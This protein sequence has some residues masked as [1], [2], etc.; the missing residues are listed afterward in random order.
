MKLQ[1]WIVTKYTSGE[2]NCKVFIVFAERSLSSVNLNICASSILLFKKKFNQGI[3]KTKKKKKSI[4][5]VY[6][7]F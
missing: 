7:H 5:Y 6:E 3:T 1:D 2:K 4:V